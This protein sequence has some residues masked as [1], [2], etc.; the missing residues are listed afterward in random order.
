MKIKW[1]SAAFSMV[2][3]LLLCST[4]ATAEPTPASVACLGRQA[5]G[6][7]KALRAETRALCRLYA[8]ALREGGRVVLWAGG[9]TPVQMNWFKT[10]FEQRFPGVTLDVLVDLSKFHDIRL[11]RAL[12]NGLATPDAVM[13][14]T[15]F[16][17]P[18]WKAQGHLELYRPIGFAAQK[19]GY[20][21]PDGAWI[22]AWNYAFVPSYAKSVVPSP[23]HIQ[24][25]LRPEFTGKLVLTWPHDDDAVLFVYDALR[26]TY[27]EQFLHRLA[28]LRP[29]FIRGTGVA[30]QVV[31]GEINA[32][33]NLTG[34]A[35]EF[36][37][38]SQYMVPADE[39]FIVWN[40]RIAILKRAAHPRAARLLVSYLS[41]AEMQSAY[42][43]WR[44]RADVGEA[45]GLPALETLAWGDPTLFTRWMED[46][47]YVAAL[48]SKMA[49]IFGPVRG[50]SPL[51]DL[52][53]LRRIGLGAEDIV[54]PPEP[55]TAPY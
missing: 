18:R 29:E 21:D 44:A 17:F 32:M 3:G 48:R 46:R 50:E 37:G 19:P 38:S 30:A 16:D 11:D 49:A 33:A 7:G 35:D 20:A 28:A 47:D 45:P 31:G 39:P 25:L 42:P 43:G 5:A 26:L 54:A 41:S 40:Q 14:Q 15:T 13:L 51:R 10:M 53:Q 52:V 4:A 22:T 55:D 24:D 9:D 2:A 34:Y 1:F 36:G 23:T 12:L 8:N 6:S 27:G